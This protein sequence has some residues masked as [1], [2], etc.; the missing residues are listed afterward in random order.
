[1]SEVEIGEGKLF[2][3][4]AYLFGIIGF[5]IVVL[6]K[7]D[8]RF[9]L[10]HAKQVLVLIISGFIVGVVGIIP[11]IGWFIVLPLGCLLLFILG[12][13]GIINAATG[14]EKPLPIIG[15]FAEKFNF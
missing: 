11:I 12:I 14:V 2:A 3:V 9:A 5:L 8:N 1:M 4:L 10:Y 6:A 13:M 15:K 7:K